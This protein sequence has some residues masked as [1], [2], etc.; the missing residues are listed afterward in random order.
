MGR[1]ECLSIPRTTSPILVIFR[2]GIGNSERVPDLD[3]NEREVVGTALRW[4]GRWGLGWR[5]HWVLG[6]GAGRPFCMMSFSS[7]PSTLAVHPR[8]KAGKI[9]HRLWLRRFGVCV[10]TLGSYSLYRKN[11]FLRVRLRF[12]LRSRMFGCGCWVVNERG[13]SLLLYDARSK[14]KFITLHRPSTIQRQ[15]WDVSMGLRVASVNQPLG[16]EG[17]S[18]LLIY[19]SSSSRLLIDMPLY[20]GWSWESS[21]N[22]AR[23][24]TI[25]WVLGRLPVAQSLVGSKTSNLYHSEKPEALLR[26]RA[27]RIKFVSTWCLDFTS[28][29]ILASFSMTFCLLSFWLSVCEYIVTESLIWNFVLL[30]KPPAENS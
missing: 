12:D 8:R 21:W 5:L 7:T 16:W 13:R 2:Q 20:G 27:V 22:W 24:L 10:W 15:R 18:T 11:P 25:P 9:R 6:N 26:H 14:K 3:L 29:S 1:D 30:R 17:L 4:L 19:V 23:V 28:H